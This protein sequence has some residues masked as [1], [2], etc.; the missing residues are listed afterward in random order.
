MLHL[1]LPK[2]REHSPNELRTIVHNSSCSLG[3]LCRS[4]SSTGRKVERELLNPNHI[5]VYFL[6]ELA[7]SGI[8]SLNGAASNAN[9]F[10]N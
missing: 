2:F 9:L 8:L 3:F 7:V 6:N 5:I 1:K 10:L 4:M